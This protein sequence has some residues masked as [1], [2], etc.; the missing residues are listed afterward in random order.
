[1]GRKRDHQYYL[2]EF[3]SL[4]KKNG[5]FVLEFNKRFNKLYNRIPVDIRPS[6][7]TTKVTY[8]TAHDLIFCNN[9]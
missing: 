4:K 3:S 7:T 8:A 2:T 5:E 6:S 1:M 9:A